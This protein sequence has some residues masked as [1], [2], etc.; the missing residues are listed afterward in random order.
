MVPCPTVM[1]ANFRYGIV[2]V[3]LFQ[4]NWSTRFSALRRRLAEAFAR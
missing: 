2:T 1:V 3:H 4:F